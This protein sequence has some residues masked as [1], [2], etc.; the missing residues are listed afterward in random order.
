MPIIDLFFS[1]EPWFVLCIPDNLPVPDLATEAAALAGD[2]VPGFKV[3]VMD[4]WSPLPSSGQH[5]LKRFNLRTLQEQREEQERVKSGKTLKDTG[6]KEPPSWTA[7]PGGNSIGFTVANGE[8]P[9][10]VPMGWFTDAKTAAEK[11]V[12]YVKPTV[13]ALTPRCAFV[14]QFVRSDIGMR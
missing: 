3:G 10:A 7:Y 11:L 8:R 12:Q 6:N 4:C 2:Y 5:V 13:H 9:L 14:H 1:G